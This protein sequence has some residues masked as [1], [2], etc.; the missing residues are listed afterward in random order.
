VREPVTCSQSARI[1][2]LRSDRSPKIAALSHIAVRVKRLRAGDVLV[3]RNLVWYGHAR[4]SFDRL[5]RAALGERQAWTERRLASVLSAAGRTAYGR[6]VG[7][8]ASIADWPVLEKE[9]VRDAPSAFVRGSQRLA[10][11]AATSGTTGVPLSVWR[12]LSSV[13]FEQ[14][15][16]DRLLARKAVDPGD[17]R[18]AVLRGDDIKDPADRDPPYWIIAGGERRLVFSSNHLNADTVTA[19]A[20]A[21]ERFQPSVLQAYPTILESFCLLLR[22]SGRKLRVPVT[23]CSSETLPESTWMLAR[24]VLATELIDYYGLAERVAF[25]YAFEPS[26]YRFLPGYSYNELLPYAEDGDAHLYELVATGL[27][28]LKMPL[29]RFRTGDLIRIDADADPLAVGYG[30][31]PF[32]EVVGRTGDY[33]VA[34]DGARLMGI[35]HIP[36]GVRNIVRMQVVQERPELVRLL[37]VPGPGFTENDRATILANAAKKL[38]PD[39]KVSLET[40]SELERTTSGKAPFVIKRTQELRA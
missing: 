23:I 8:P 30:V 33:L 31:V 32:P 1:H 27:L 25:A 17:F 38:P 19:F 12:S 4:R 6:D 14:A 21:L 20:D 36:R 28:N 3:R 7:A 29:I 13:I 2:D 34:P 9:Q 18:A 26:A 11:T 37:V 10:S 40:V 5:E 39:M 16:I 22:Q 24:K 15:A 35:D